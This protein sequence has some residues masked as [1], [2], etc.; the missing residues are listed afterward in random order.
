M[1]PARAEVR[2]GLFHHFMGRSSHVSVCEW[3]SVRPHLTGVNGHIYTL[4]MGFESTRWETSDMRVSPH[5]LAAT[6]DSAVV[7]MSLLL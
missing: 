7:K 5:P 6:F 3:V 4:M 2:D 1:S